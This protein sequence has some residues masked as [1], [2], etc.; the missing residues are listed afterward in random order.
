MSNSLQ[1]YGLAPTIAS[2]WVSPG[3]N[4]GVSCLVLFQGI[5]LTQGS[6]PHLL[7]LLHWL[8][9]SLP[10]KPPGKPKI[11]VLSCFSQLCKPM[12][13]SPPGASVHQILQARILEWVAMPSSRGSSQLRDQTHVSYIS[14]IGRQV[15]Y[16]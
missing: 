1:P 10:W 5:F 6:N 8:T 2:P 3:K 13:C 12:Y 16:H 4:T 14:W 9:G 15:L 7:Q 11:H